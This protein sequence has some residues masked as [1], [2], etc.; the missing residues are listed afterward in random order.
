MGFVEFD[1]GEAAAVDRDAIAELH[2]FGELVRAGE[3]DTQT[4]AIFPVVE[5]INF[6]DVFGD[7]CK[8][9]ENILGLRNP[10]RNG[11]K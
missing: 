8:H 2:F 9:R 3:A 11:S 1:D 6:S 10:G 4:A 5:R 7:P